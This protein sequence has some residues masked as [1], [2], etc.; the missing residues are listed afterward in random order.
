MY[1]NELMRQ[2]RR[3]AGGAAE[4]YRID[5]HDGKAR[6]FAVLQRSCGQKYSE[7]E[8]LEYWEKECHRLI[9][10]PL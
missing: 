5:P 4:E 9:I 10:V 1:V 8:L 3:G 2:R 6:T 7:A